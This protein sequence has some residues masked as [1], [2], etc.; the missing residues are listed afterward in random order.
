M[1]RLTLSDYLFILLL[2]ILLTFGVSRLLHTWLSNV[3]QEASGE[4]ER[5]GRVY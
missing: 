2:I 1:H 4:V 3:A 5:A